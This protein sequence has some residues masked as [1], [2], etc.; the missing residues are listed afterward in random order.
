MKW[1]RGWGR[2]S[3]TMTLQ[4]KHISAMTDDELTAIIRT[5]KQMERYEQREQT[6]ET[7]DD[8]TPTIN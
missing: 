6:N 1:D 7:A 4:Q 8:V 2:A 5:A 3:Q